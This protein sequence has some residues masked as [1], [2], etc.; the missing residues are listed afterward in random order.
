[1]ISSDDVNLLIL[2]YL[3]EQGYS[4]SSYV[5]EQECKYKNGLEIPKG[6]LMEIIEK[7]MHYTKLE[8]AHTKTLQLWCG[9]DED[10]VE[11][12]DQVQDEAMHLQDAMMDRVHIDQDIQIMANSEDALLFGSSEFCYQYNKELVRLPMVSPV[13]ALFGKF[14]GLFDGKILELDF[15]K[16]DSEVVLDLK[17]PIFAFCGNNDEMAVISAV[18]DLVIMDASFGQVLHREK[19]DVAIIDAI[20]Y[21]QCVLA[22]TE[23]GF[24]ISI[25]KRKKENQMEIDGIEDYVKSSTSIHEACILGIKSH[26]NYFITFGNDKKCQ[27]FRIDEDYTTHLLISIT[28][29]NPVLLADLSH[30]IAVFDG[31]SVLIYDYAGALL[32]TFYHSNISALRWDIELPQLYVA[33]ENLLMCY[34]HD[35][36]RKWGCKQSVID[37]I[38]RRKDIVIC[39]ER[40]CIKLNKLVK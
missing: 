2:R 30:Q 12:S 27:L 16:Q 8:Y 18:G 17:S 22:V 19:H 6:M 15:K 37:V 1:M 4:H 23:D 40:M 11:I 38:P 39:C 29:K 33:A 36:V 10:I 3:Q 31:E 32:Y 25:V 21:N 28:T 14:A 7:G 5:F 9:T 35:K 34:T 20:W 13:T 26:S 24:L